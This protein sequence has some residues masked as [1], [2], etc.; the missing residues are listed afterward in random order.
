MKVRRLARIETDDKSTEKIVV[1]FGSY[2]T[3]ADGTAKFFN[4]NDK[5]DNFAEK[6]EYVADALTQKLSILQKEL[7]WNVS[8]GLPLMEKLNSKTALDATIAQI[9]S[10]QPEVRD[11]MVFESNIIAHKY[12][13]HIEIDTIYGPV[14]LN[15]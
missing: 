1:W 7:W 6:Q 4:P 15:F 13:A 14:S 2:G 3:N 9:I 12:S 10:A 5:H 11:I 8:Y